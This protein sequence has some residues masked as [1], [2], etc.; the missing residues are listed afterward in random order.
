MVVPITPLFVYVRTFVLLELTPFRSL[1]GSIHLN[2]NYY[3]LP[4]ALCT[5][6]CTELEL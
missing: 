1:F 3:W 4:V 5:F 6:Y 2:S